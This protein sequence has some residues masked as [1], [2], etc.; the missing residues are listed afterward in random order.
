MAPRY[1]CALGLIA[2]VVQTSIVRQ[3]LDMQVCEG[4]EMG[5][6]KEDRRKRLKWSVIGRGASPIT[7]GRVTSRDCRSKKAE[8][9]PAQMGKVDPGR[10]LTRR[11]HGEGDAKVLQA[12]RQQRRPGG[13][14]RQ[15]RQSLSVPKICVPEK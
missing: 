15:G 4:S 9:A 3:R 13:S 2:D 12:A 7:D 1:K 6:G 11:G 5:E 8:S 14:A 10:P